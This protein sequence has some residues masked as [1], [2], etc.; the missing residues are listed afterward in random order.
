MNIKW[1]GQSCFLISSSN[2]TKIITDPFDKKMGYSLPTDDADIVTVSHDHMDHNNV[3]S[4]NGNYT[5]YRTT[6]KFTKNGI[7]IIGIE[8][9]H[10]NAHG[11]KRGKNIIYKFNVDGINICH[12]GDLGH[13]LTEDQLNQ[14]GKVDVLLI[15]VG[16]I[17]TINAKEATEMVGQINPSITIPMH[18]STKLLSGPISLLLS[19]ADKFIA[20]CDKPFKEENELSI[21]LNNIGEYQGYVILN[22]SK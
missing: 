2:G 16:G 5:C 7:E 9:F 14:I 1:Y 19:K 20:L 18:Y 21:D 15:P 10:D 6:G 17:F 8:T 12:C 22:I 3:K 13:L 11:S 4:V